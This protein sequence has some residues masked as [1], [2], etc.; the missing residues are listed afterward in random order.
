MKMQI[1][2]VIASLTLLGAASVQASVKA[3]AQVTAAKGPAQ[4]TLRLQKTTVKVKDSLWYKLE[5]K[6]IGK[7]KILV[8]DRIFKDPYAIHVYSKSRYG[9]YLEI[10]DSSGE[11]LKVKWGNY[12][13]RYDWEGPEGVEYSYTPEEKKELSMLDA[14]WKKSGMTEQQQS[15]AWTEW[16]NELYS[17]KNKEELRDP[18]RQ[19]WLNPGASTATFAWITP[20]E[21]IDYPG[22]SD[23]EES[24]RQGY[25]EL[26]IYQ[27]FKAGKYRIRA[28]YDHSL[29][30]QFL[31]KHKIS[32][33]AARVKFKTPFIEFTVRP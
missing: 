13:L 15:I 6:N 28:V 2:A 19:H 32:P 26:W 16:A 11:L 3:A 8:D 29:S 21:I 9:L 20:G 14:Q 12:R 33:D 5:L 25:A 23:D 4:I 22:R 31:E 24:L 10:I 30:E 18:A 27:F 17:R 1:A 7:Q